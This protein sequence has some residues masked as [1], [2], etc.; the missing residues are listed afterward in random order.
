MSKPQHISSECPFSNHSSPEEAPS[1]WKPPTGAVAQACPLPAEEPGLWMQPPGRGCALPSSGAL[2]SGAA[3]A[4]VTARSP[5]LCSC[6]LPRAG[7]RYPLRSLSP[8]EEE[9]GRRSPARP[10]TPSLPGTGPAL[11][12]FNSLAAAAR[13][14]ACVRGVPRPGLGSLSA[15]GRLWLGRK[16]GSLSGRP[17]LPSRV[18]RACL[19]GPGLG[20]AGGPKASVCGQGWLLGRSERTRRTPLLPPLRAAPSSPS[21][22][23]GGFRHPR[24][25]QE[26]GWCGALARQSSS[27]CKNLSE[28]WFSATAAGEPPEIFLNMPWPGRTPR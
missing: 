18:A 13:S 9:S 21:T 10:R 8:R 19:S 25:F 12:A 27:T 11:S 6:P 15:E 28:Q 3:G 1:G 17:G 23:T 5:L 14:Q 16:P 22:L 2:G 20:R 26:N 24:H 4:A 7:P